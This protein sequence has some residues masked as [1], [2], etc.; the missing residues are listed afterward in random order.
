MFVEGFTAG[1]G[2]TANAYIANATAKKHTTPAANDT[3]RSAF[4][5][6]RSCRAKAS[7]TG[8][9]RSFANRFRSCKYR[10]SAYKP[11]ASARIIRIGRIY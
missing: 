9:L 5:R 2:S 1:D 4:S 11:A 10:L 3:D 6:V 8:M 7:L